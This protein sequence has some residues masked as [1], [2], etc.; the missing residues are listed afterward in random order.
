MTVIKPSIF[1]MNEIYQ[2]LKPTGQF[3]SFTPA[4]SRELNQSNINCLIPINQDPTHVNTWTYESFKGYFCP[5]DMD[6][7]D[8]FQQQISNGIRTLFIA[9]PWGERSKFP[10]EG[11]FYEVGHDGTHLTMI[12]E[13]PKCDN[14]NIF[15]K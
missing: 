7:S 13:K 14:S 9:L 8:R 10:V 3:L 1:L 5:P 15:F 12:L 4:I 11:V 2:V 6:S